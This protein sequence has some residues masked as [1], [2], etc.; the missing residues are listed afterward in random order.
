[1][2]LKRAAE[3]QREGVPRV[4]YY[5]VV[6]AALLETF[7]TQSYY[8]ILAR[9]RDPHPL[10]VSRSRQ[11]DRVF[12]PAFFSARYARVG[13]PPIVDRRPVAAPLV[14]RV[15]PTTSTC[16]PWPPRDRIRQR[17]RAQLGRDD[18]IRLVGRR[19]PAMNSSPPYAHPV[20]RAPR[21]CMR[22]GPTARQTC[23]RPVA[24]VSCLLE[25]NPPEHDHAALL[26]A[27]ARRISRKRIHHHL[28]PYRPVIRSKRRGSDSTNFSPCQRHAATNPTSDQGEPRKF[29]AT[30]S[31][32]SDQVSWNSGLVS[33]SVPHSRIL[34]GARPRAAVQRQ[35]SAPP[36]AT[37]ASGEPNDPWS[38]AVPSGRHQE[39]RIWLEKNAWC[40]HL[41][42]RDR[43]RM[44][45]RRITVGFFGNAAD[46]RGSRSQNLGSSRPAPSGIHTLRKTARAPHTRDG[47]LL[48]QL[49]CGSRRT[50]GHMRAHHQH[51][52]LADTVRPPLRRLHSG[53]APRSRRR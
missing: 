9:L 7:R 37:T 45:F 16:A 52:R 31:F 51:R 35:H 29:G 5:F 6:A 26:D 17:Q 13:R 36:S 23:R 42:R 4:F 46:A 22:R 2:L 12:G 39:D 8:R 41:P 34:A 28:T 32:P 18:R 24:S 3:P 33:S 44:I 1:M 40:H 30:R 10:R 49:D 19:Q 14:R 27:D 43:A 20:H 38:G 47:Q 11:T 25:A 53:P 50:P 15:P 21:S 48:A